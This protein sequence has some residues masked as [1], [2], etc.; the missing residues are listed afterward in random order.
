MISTLEPQ[1]LP[2]DEY[3]R[4]L[5]ENAHPPTW[6]NPQPRGRYNLVVV[7]AG[8]AGLVSAAG[9]AQLGA[10]VALVERH[11]MGGD[12]LNYGC[13]P[14]KALIRAARAAY[15]FS[16][17]REFGI[18]L[19]ARPQ[20]DFAEVMRRVRRVRAEISPH[21]SVQ[22]FT[23]LG[24]DVFLGNARFIS[25]DAIE[26]GGT[27]LKF[28]KAIIATGA[29]PAELS[30]PGLKEAGFLTNET[31]FS[32][33]ELPRRLIVIGAGPI[34]CELAQA[35][36]RLGSTVSILGIHP[37]LI[38]R[39]DPDAGKILQDQ[40]EREGIDLYLGAQARRVRQSADGK[41]VFFDRGSG[42]EAIT[43]DE[44]LVAI[45]RTPNVEGLDLEAAG[46]AY[47]KKGITAD[48]TLRTSNP[49]IYAAGDISSAYQFTHAAEA[50]A[51]IALQNS[52]FFGRK[53]AGGL[54]IPWTTYTDPEVAHL[55]LTQ[56]DAQ[57]RADVETFMLRLDDN[58]RAVVDGETAGFARAYV[59]RKHGRLLGAT[60]V[61]RHAGESI[62]EFALA[63]QKGMKLRDLGGVIHPYPTQAEIIKRLGDTS[64]KSRLKPWMKKLLIRQF[65]WRR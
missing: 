62:G 25:G 31:V 53:R 28:S 8:T 58:D 1:V 39:D 2:G 45:G 29:R 46:V 21:D 17:A 22:R 4:I 20:I 15:A 24:A 9:A 44:I 63:I 60:L 54:V 36:A 49:H 7:G 57:E 41:T 30:V 26:V 34:G 14:S 33:T 3:N 5:I 12:C 55:G 50:L 6:R 52:L 13:V 59:D 51:R 43:G 65:A 35:F 37:T 16:E 32:L 48:A 64:Q 23:D 47:D 19:T 11:L 42:E 18:S 40:F 27:R 10:R 56:K 38:P 61:N